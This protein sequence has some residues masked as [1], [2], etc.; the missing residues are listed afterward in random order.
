M[1]LDAVLGLEP[2]KMGSL[3]NPKVKQA[4]SYMAAQ[5]HGPLKLTVVASRIGIHPSHLCRLFKK[6][7]GMPFRRCILIMRL[8]KARQLLAESEKSI[9]QISFEIGFGCPEAFSRA[10]KRQMGC[11]P[12]QYRKHHRQG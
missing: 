7:L 1:N 12:G 10:F 4:L 2:H 9:K 8:H 5:Y 6:E 11:P 3:V